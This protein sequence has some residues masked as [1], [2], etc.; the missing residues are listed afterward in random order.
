MAIRPS[1]LLCILVNVLCLQ[2]KKH[3]SRGLRA[4]KRSLFSPTTPKPKRQLP[5]ASSPITT[6]SSSTQVTPISSDNEHSLGGVLL[7]ASIGETFF[8]DSDYSVHELPDNIS[9]KGSEGAIMSTAAQLDETQV[10]VNTALISRIEMLEAQNS[11]LHKKVSGLKPKHFRLEDVVHSD[12]LVYF[13]TGFESYEILLAFYDFLGPAV[14]RLHYWG[15]K[16]SSGKKRKMKLSPLN[17]LF[18]TLIRTDTPRP[19]PLTFV[20]NLDKSSGVVPRQS[21]GRGS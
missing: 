18:M 6:P 13:Y 4:A 15:S 20:K 1:H 19:L 11:A 10:L 2:K 5:C 16:S 7:S 3:S 21:T 9:S 8:S 14:N 12:S 17:Q